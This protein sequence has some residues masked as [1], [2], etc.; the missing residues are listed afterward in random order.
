M[1]S[2]GVQATSAPVLLYINLLR[3]GSTD[4]WE[5]SPSSWDGLLRLCGR[6]LRSNRGEIRGARPWRRFPES[7]S[8]LRGES[9]LR[10]EPGE[11]WSI[12]ARV[13]PG[14]RLDL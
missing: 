7:A 5:R 9:W 10:E 13:L 14:L 2:W 8:L 4:G 1:Y 3:K 6:G 12:D 11:S